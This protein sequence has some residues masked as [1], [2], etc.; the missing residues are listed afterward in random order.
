MQVKVSQLQGIDKSVRSSNSYEMVD[1]TDGII[2][3]S[4]VKPTL[5]TALMSGMSNDKYL[6]DT[7]FVYDEVTETHQLPA[8]KR[9]DQVGSVRVVLDSAKE[10]TFYVPSFDVSAYAT[11]ADA[12]QRK[13]FSEDK[14]SMEEIVA[15]YGAKLDKVW[16]LHTEIAMGQLLTQ[17]TNYLAG[18][19]GKEYNFYTDIYGSARPAA[20]DLDLGGA[21]DPI[22][23]LNNISDKMQEAASLGNVTYTDMIMVCGGTLF[24]GL[25]A[26]EQEQATAVFAINP[27][28]VLN[29][30][31][32]GVERS[33]FGGADLN[34]N[35]RHFRSALTGI[36]YVRVADNIT[37]VAPLVGASNG[38]LIP[39]GASNMFTRVYAPIQHKD[40]FDRQA[41][42]KYG[43]RYE[44]DRDGTTLTQ[45]SNCLY[46]GR[47][48]AVIQHVTTSS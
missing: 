23:V 33:N 41:L 40:Y 21:G 37:G 46:M 3:N 48:Q 4:G 7:K 15:L 10:K 1:T 44:H 45:E 34:F 24:D 16:D 13:P 5:L 2:Y 32:Y 28:S 30:E 43:F 47:N 11:L 14:Y 31:M 36:T 42:P 6:T 35:R 18:G 19:P 17:D 12:K 8:G 38:Y 25:L 29:L 26:L 9:H 20:T 39:T 22:A 27:T